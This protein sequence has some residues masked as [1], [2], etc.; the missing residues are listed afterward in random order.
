MGFVNC[1]NRFLV[2]HSFLTS[3]NLGIGFLFLLDLKMP[4]F[5]LPYVT[6]YIEISCSPLCSVAVRM[7]DVSVISNIT[8]VLTPHPGKK[9]KH[10]NVARSGQTDIYF[11]HNRR[12]GSN[13]PTTAG[14]RQQEQDSRLVKEKKQCIS[15]FFSPY[16]S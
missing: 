8:P 16:F 13:I 3:W 11:R 1:C 4:C 15:D 6:C 10:S 5:Q 2:L 14:N 12:T 9:H 7:I